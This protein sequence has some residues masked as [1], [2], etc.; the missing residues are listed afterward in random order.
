MKGCLWL[1]IYGHKS[2]YCGSILNSDWS[3]LLLV[4]THGSFY[5]KQSILLVNIQSSLHPKQDSL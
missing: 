5:C 4:N 2:V 3:L 1:F